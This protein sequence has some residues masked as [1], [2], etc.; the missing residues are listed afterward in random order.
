MVFTSNTEFHNKI[1]VVTGAGGA[2]GGAVAEALGEAGVK[3]VVLDINRKTVEERVERILA[4]GGKALPCVCSV[5]EEEKLE[6][7]L[8]S[9]KK[10]FGQPHYLINAAG[11]NNPA[12]STDCEFYSQEGEG[13]T[14]TDLSVE[15][16]RKTFDLNYFG[17]VIP[18]KVFSKGM[19]EN[20]YGSIINFSSIAAL[21]PL[22]KVV[23]YSNAKAAVLNFTKWLAV[24]YAK[25]NVRVNALAPGFVMTEQLKFLHINEKGEYTPRARMVL[26]HTPM[27]RYGQEKELLGAVFWLLSENAGFVTGSVI[28][29]DGGFSSYAV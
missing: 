1:S 20:G 29:L 9:I 24:H 28:T 8:V 3:V 21:T 11:G 7:A 18:T 13:K 6:E 10:E 16:M 17:T 5:L 12:G 25:S 14:F 4:K 27:G 26:D 19:L 15:G 2:L 23:A 22:T